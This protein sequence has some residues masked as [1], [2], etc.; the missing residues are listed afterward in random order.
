[1]TAAAGG[2]ITLANATGAPGSTG[3][4]LSAS[5]VDDANQTTKLAAELWVFNSVPTSF[6]DGAAFAPTDADLL[7]CVAVIPLPNVYVGNAGAGAAGNCLLQSDPVNR[8]FQASPSSANLLVYVV[9]RNAYVPT[10][11]E[12]L[13]PRLS[14]LAD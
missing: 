8:V 11:G 7:N 13:T 10:T 1:V 4:I 5:M 3:L 9:A 12:I 2:P 6:A 14:I